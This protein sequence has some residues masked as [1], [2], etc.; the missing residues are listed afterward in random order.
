MNTDLST[1]EDD[2]ALG[3]FLGSLANDITSHPGRLQ[4][5]DVGLVVRI[6][7]LAG[8]TEINFDAPLSAD[9]E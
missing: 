6:N 7:S 3:Q 9:D 1:S 2:P 8:K 5:I 4:V